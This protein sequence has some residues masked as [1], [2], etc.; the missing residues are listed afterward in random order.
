MAQ[1]FRAI[2]PGR[3]WAGCACLGL[4]GGGGSTEILSEVSG[5][6]R[7]EVDVAGPSSYP[8]YSGRKT[9]GFY[10]IALLGGGS[11]PNEITLLRRP[12]RLT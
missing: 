4:P 6:I 7:E 3:R 2:E 9:T 11:D 8:M 10:R 12:A 1:A 5:D